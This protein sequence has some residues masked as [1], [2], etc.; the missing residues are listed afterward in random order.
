MNRTNW[1]HAGIAA[2]LM[3]AVFLP[4]A[5]LAVPG[6]SLIAFAVAVTWFLARECTQHEYKLGMA[7]GWRWGQPLP[8]RWW[9]GFARGWSRDSLL[10]W[11]TPLGAC[12]LLLAGLWLLPLPS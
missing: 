7:R 5:L 10:D 6:A 9:E 1:E 2:G 12:L 11:L 4:L 3:L 8:V